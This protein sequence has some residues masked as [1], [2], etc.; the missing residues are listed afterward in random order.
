MGYDTRVLGS[1]PFVPELR[2]DQDLNERLSPPV[3]L[4]ALVDA[5]TR[6]RVWISATSD[7][8]ADDPEWSRRVP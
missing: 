2:R 3:N 4:D 5:V 8:G 6:R 1:G 7:E